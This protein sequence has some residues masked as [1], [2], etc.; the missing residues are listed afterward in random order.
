M[1]Y[2]VDYNEKLKELVVLTI[3]LYKNLETQH[4]LVYIDG[5]EMVGT[6]TLLEGLKEEFNK[7]DRCIYTREPSRE[8]K[9]E[10]IKKFGDKAFIETSNNGEI[11]DM[12]MKD[13]KINQSISSDQIIISDRGIFS[14]IVYQS[15]ILDP[16]LSYQDIVNNCSM[17]YESAVVNGIKMPL[18]TFI[19]CTVGG[20]WNADRFEFVKRLN[21]R[22]K[23]N[24]Q[25]LDALDDVATAMVINKVYSDLFRYLRNIVNIYTFEFKW[26]PSRIKFAVASVI[27]ETYKIIS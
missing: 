15:G 12:F 27:D 17:I 1:N 11:I 2:N 4:N 19:L 9:K 22:T 20:D 25:E 5:G 7:T 8:I 24:E 6:S 3:N 14:S 23:N 13:R 21:K 10:I 18:M 16:E 26:A